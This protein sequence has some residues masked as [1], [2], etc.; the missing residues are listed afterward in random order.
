V[1]QARLQQ[2]LSVFVHSGQQF[3]LDLAGDELRESFAIVSESF[4]IVSDGSLHAFDQRVVTHR[5]LS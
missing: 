5:F 1:R 3:A 2:R 4:A